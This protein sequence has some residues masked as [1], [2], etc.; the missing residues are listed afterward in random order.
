MFIP[1][2]I[3]KTRPDKS[4][5]C[6]APV[7]FYLSRAVRTAALVMA[8]IGIIG[9]SLGQLGESTGI[10]SPRHPS[11]SN[12][13]YYL[14]C[15]YDQWFCAAWVIIALV[16]YLWSGTASQR[17]LVSSQK[18]LAWLHFASG[19]RRWLIGALALAGFVV[20]WVGTYL[21]CLNHP[22][23]MDEFFPNFQ[24]D[25]LL[26]GHIRGSLPREW[27]PFVKSMTPLTTAYDPA[28]QTWTSPYLPLYAAL[29]APLRLIGGDTALNPLLTAAA[30]GTIA[31]VA[32]AIWP[33]AQR[34]TAPLLA[35][36]LLATSPQVLITGMTA[37]TMPAHLLFNLFWLWL[38]LREDRWGHGLAPWLGVVAM[39]LHQPNVHPLFVAPFLLR[40]A[41]DCRW[42]R[43]AYY[44]A[45]YS[46]G[47]VG[48]FA[49]LKWR[50]PAIPVGGGVVKFAGLLASFFQAPEPL[51]WVS[52]GM[53]VCQIF[54]WQNVLVGGLAVC[55][56]LGGH[57]R[58]LPR[59][60]PELTAGMVLPLAFYLFFSSDQGHGW[61]NR[62]FHPFLGNLVLL[63][64]AGW[65][66]LVE[67]VGPVRARWALVV[68]AVLAISVQLPLRASEAWTVSRP[69][70]EASRW[71]R[72][73]PEPF[74]I[75]DTRAVWYGQDLVR[76]D[77]RLLNSP[78]L[79]FLHRITREQ[80]L[81]L[82]ERG[83]LRLVTGGELARFG[84][85]ELR[86]PQPSTP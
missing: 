38:Y 18:A 74:V 81:A 84:L 51:S 68:T 41:L 42:R 9:C 37:Y 15:A 30:V 50:T 85:M 70:A 35:A 62:Y 24:A 75:V 16:G 19:E 82:S 66:R 23:A 1:S 43:L 67:A 13:F 4:V 8:A 83:P 61:G 29:R 45:V 25:L 10:G 14:F 27:W 71:L 57:W 48:W 6:R 44:S 2:S 5:Q 47:I 73:L 76:N 49:Y 56:L 55:A 11:S 39:G 72:S 78:K 20:A 69:F 31:A 32:R 46:L 80:A 86:R 21:V 28:H 7:E 63:A 79:L 52:L 3:A 40:M 53:G 26:N 33:L 77:A 22:F 64:V 34:P 58:L 17:E 65:P 12:I 59:P 36:L 54:V 60:L